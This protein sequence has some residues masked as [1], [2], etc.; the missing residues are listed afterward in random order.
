MKKYLFLATMIFLLLGCSSPVDDVDEGPEV[1]AELAAKVPA[2]LEPNRGARDCEVFNTVIEGDQLVMNVWQNAAQGHDCPDDW[3]ASIDP[4]EY[5]VDGPRWQPID[6]ILS[7][8]EDLNFILDEASFLGRDPVIQE[9]PEGSGITM[10]LAATVEIGPIQA[11]ANNFNVEL[12]D[13]GVV[14]PEIQQAIFGNFYGDNVYEISEI[15]RVFNTFW[16]YKAGNPVYVISDGE[17]EYAM[18]YYT[19]IENK[20]LTNEETVADLNSQFEEI[21]PGY[22]Y[23][24]RQFSEDVHVLDLDGLQY[25]INDEF[26]NS[27]DRLWCGESQVPYTILN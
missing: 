9:I 3:L 20:S 13:S 14:P 4:R 11:I 15:D 1:I 2:D 6:Y 5:F 25:V 10:V 16:V 23:E 27:Y 17:C 26:G 22:T 18:K 19:S 8:D 24:V 7:V 12:D 21:P